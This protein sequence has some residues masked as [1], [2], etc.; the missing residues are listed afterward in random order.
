MSRVSKEHTVSGTGSFSQWKIRV[1]R[2]RHRELLVDRII[3]KWPKYRAPAP[4]LP[5]ETALPSRSLRVGWSVVLWNSRGKVPPSKGSELTVLLGFVL[6]GLCSGWNDCTGCRWLTWRISPVTRPPS[7][8]EGRVR[9][10]ECGWFMLEGRISP[11]KNTPHITAGGHYVMSQ[12]GWKRDKV[13]ISSHFTFCSLSP[14]IRC[15]VTFNVFHL[16]LANTV[17][18][19]STAETCW[20]WTANY[21]WLAHQT[22]RWLNCGGRQ[23]ELFPMYT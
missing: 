14:C 18:Y 23:T 2:W 10:E 12:A 21:Y 19:C 5:S 22:V 4:S 3:R 17:W 16:L 8:W 7:S 11:A 20:F 9:T 6:Q 15:L 1:P 13:P